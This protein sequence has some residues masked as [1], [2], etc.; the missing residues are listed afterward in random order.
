[1]F[2]RVLGYEI[3]QTF[4]KTDYRYYVA[5]FITIGF[6]VCFLRFPNAFGRLIES[7]RDVGTSFA[8]YVCD[9]FEINGGVSATVNDFA[10]IPFFDLFGHGQAEVLPKEFVAFKASWDRYW[11]LWRSKENFGGYMNAL[12]C[13]LSSFAKFF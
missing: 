12:S 2:I 6:V 1:M 9:I 11:Q 5:I 3:I 10:K 13:G 8:Y 7:I 4:A